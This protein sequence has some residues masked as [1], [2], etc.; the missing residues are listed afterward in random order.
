M[1]TVEVERPTVIPSQRGGVA[2]A[3]IAGVS[4]MDD[5]ALTERARELAGEISAAEANLAA[6]LAEAERRDIHHRW[7]CQ[8]IER[9]AGWHCQLSWPRA[10]SLTAVGRAMAELPTMAEAVAD[11][12]LSFDKAK[13]VTK[14]GEASTEGALVQMA[15]HATTSQT[16]R[17][18]AT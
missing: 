18:C 6:V 14:S 15:V 3:L 16:Q 11:G 4:A 17:I 8:T 1:Y 13:C 12:T 2:A 7:E 9:F 10:H 5:E